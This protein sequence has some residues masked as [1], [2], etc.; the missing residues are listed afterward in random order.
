M[1]SVCCAIV[2]TISAAPESDHVPVA[3]SNRMSSSVLTPLETRFATCVGVTDTG[4]A[5]SIVSPCLESA[6]AASNY[7]PRP[8]SNPTAGWAGCLQ[9]AAPPATSPIST[10]PQG[11]EGHTTAR[12]T[13]PHVMR[14]CRPTTPASNHPA[15]L[16]EA[17]GRMFKHG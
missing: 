5:L 13:G 15:E 10:R 3:T 17:V 7:P 1:W 12:R 11:D 16:S 14:T 8:S 6:C 9:G 4:P 2:E